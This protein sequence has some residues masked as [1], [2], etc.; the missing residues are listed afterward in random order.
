LLSSFETDWQTVKNNFP[1]AKVFNGIHNDISD[2]VLHTSLKNA[3]PPTDDN[4]NYNLNYNE[5]EKIYGIIL[6]DEVITYSHNDIENEMKILKLDDIIL[7]SSAQ[8]EFI[9]SFYTGNLELSIVKNNFPVILTDQNNNKYDV[10]G[11]PVNV[12]GISPLMPTQSYS[13]SW[14][15]WKN[16]FDSFSEIK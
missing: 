12:Y 4:N 3:P 11:K 15:A 16:F 6:P 9:V 14:W 13:A 2:S 7:V 1:N 10:F 5:G 8:P